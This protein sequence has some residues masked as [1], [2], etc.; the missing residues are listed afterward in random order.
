MDESA[1]ADLKVLEF[2][3]F[4][5][6]PFCTKLMADLG[7]D[8]IKIEKPSTGDTAR[9]AGPFLGGVPHP[10][11]SGL[12]LYL[13][14]NKRSVTLD[15]ETT[16]GADIF[17]ELAKTADVIVENMPPGDMKRFG[18]GYDSLRRI[19][20]GIILT[21]IAPFGQFGPY[22]HWKA[23]D[24]VC[25]HMSGLAYH[26]PIGGVDSPERPPL[27]PGGRQSDFI[28]GSTAAVATM[29]AVIARRTNGVGQHLDISQQEAIAS[30]LRHQV[31][32]Q[33]YDPD[34][35]LNRRQFDSSARLP[36]ILPC[37]DGFVI[38][39]CREAS[40]WNAL[41]TL[42]SG[43]GWE[44]DERILNTFN[45]EFSL[46]AALTR[47][48]EILQPVV[49]EWAM[50]FTKE[51][52]TAAARSRGI[53]IIAPVGPYGF[54][55]LPCK[56]G[57]LVNR[58]RQRDQWRDLLALIA[59]DRWEKDKGLKALF[60][61]DFSLAGFWIEAGATIWP[62]MTRWAAER[63]REDILD[64]VQ[65]R[66]IPIGL[67]GGFFGFGYL[68]C[69]DGYVISGCREPYQWR[70]FIGLVSGDDWETDERFRRLLEGEFDV[71]VFLAQ[72]GP[73]IWPM[74]TQWAEGR[75]REEITIAAQSRGIPI[76]P[77]N[78]TEDLFTSSH[79]SEREFLVE[80][81]HP[82][83]GRLHYP[84]APYHL[85]ETPWRVKRAAPMLGQHNQEVFGGE[86]GYSD[87]A[88][89]SMESSGI[90]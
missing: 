15:P 73:T 35:E 51:E 17:R 53:P 74:M 11:K 43:D 39:R 89:A 82:Q 56:D 68:P 77:C 83:A 12:F 10:E 3:D 5:S 21:S 45:G 20:P 24:L 26:T 69:K 48:S 58:C 32:F 88:L 57:F 29:F 59:G 25:T 44:N 79:F 70:E 38:N 65:S 60:D 62:M 72:A 76:V 22:S 61:G 49:A 71:G 9:I 8:V 50:Q 37:K 75:T 1:L 54:V 64:A 19:N 63:T 33:T 67:P 16:A 55:Y 28:A 13:N 23:N 42:A 31:A 30:F 7:A 80:I 36:R 85:S 40:Q 86:L 2:S 52:V 87:E 84:G 34:I 78:T 90:V 81:G 14:T 6:G 18:F 41:L 47:A 4:I 46:A 66:N 27:K